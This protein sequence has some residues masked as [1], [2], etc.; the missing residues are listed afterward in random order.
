MGKGN[1]SNGSMDNNAAA[2]GGSSF[3]GMSD[4]EDFA[5]INNDNTFSNANGN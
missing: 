3:G 2:M 4:N 5:D 1:N